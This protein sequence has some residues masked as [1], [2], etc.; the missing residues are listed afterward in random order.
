VVK[1]GVVGLT[2]Y[3]AT[4]WAG[5]NIR[6]NA[7]APGGVENGQSAE[8]IERLSAEVPLDRMAKPDEFSGILSFLLSSDASYIN[9]QEIVADGGRS[10]W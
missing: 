7:L 1:H 4:F 3:F 6:V 10:I 2:R 5:S 8:F 9:G